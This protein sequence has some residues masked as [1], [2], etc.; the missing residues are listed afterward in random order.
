L[1][2]ATPSYN[3]DFGTVIQLVGAVQVR[4]WDIE[5]ILY[6]HSAPDHHSTMTFLNALPSVV[7]MRTR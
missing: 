2:T 1:V 3:P 6:R 4:G 7:L 5:A